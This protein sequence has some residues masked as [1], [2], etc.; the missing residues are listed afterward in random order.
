MQL[1]GSLG[2]GKIALLWR[3]VFVRGICSSFLFLVHVSVTLL[4]RCFAPL[5]HDD[6][7]DIVV[8]GSVLV[9]NVLFFSLE[10]NCN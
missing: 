6:Y 10:D 3:V 2:G 7:V 1:V 5:M 9:V 4:I 8:E